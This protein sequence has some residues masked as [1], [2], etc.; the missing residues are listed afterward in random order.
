M[1]RLALSQNPRIL[2]IDNE[3]DLFNKQIFYQ[4]AYDKIQTNTSDLDSVKF[5]LN[6][7][8]EIQ[9]ISPLDLNIDNFISFIEDYENSADTIKINSIEDYKQFVEKNVSDSIID[10]DT[11]QIGDFY[12]EIDLESLHE[13]KII[14]NKMGIAQVLSRLNII[15]TLSHL[16]RL[17]TPI[18]R[19][20]KLIKPRQ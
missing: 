20:G 13:K 10:I 6:N 9:M 15:S 18:E 2:I 3:I 12:I 1:S 11:F 14:T 19:S 4:T 7:A 5:Y 17:N 8:K 16:R